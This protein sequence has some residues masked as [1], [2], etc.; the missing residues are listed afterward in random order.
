LT[1]SGDDV[2]LGLILAI[3]RWKIILLPYTDITDFNESIIQEAYIRT[4]TLSANLIE[5][6]VVG[7]ADERLVN[8]L[9]QIISEIPFDKNIV[10]ASLNW[11]SSSG[12][13]VLLG[14]LC[15]VLLV[16]EPYQDSNTL[17]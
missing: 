14:I 3:N 13:Y 4:T 5:S 16:G 2:L 7:Q 8:A 11:G 1:P 17:T 12:Y 6:A 10:D 15:A 9:D